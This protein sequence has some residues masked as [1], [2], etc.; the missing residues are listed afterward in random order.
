[1][2]IRRTMSNNLENS[3][4]SSP[5]N[6]DISRILIQHKENATSQ[7]PDESKITHKEIVENDHFDRL[8][9]NK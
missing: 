9:T 1:M 3:Q 8:K 5:T 7:S 4:S 6:R 2:E